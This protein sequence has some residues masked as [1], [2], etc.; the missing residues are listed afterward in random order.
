M[1]KKNSRFVTMAVV[2]C[3]LFTMGLMSPAMAKVHKVNIN[4]ADKAQLMTL[5]YIGQKLAERIIEYRKKTPFKSANEIMMVKG[6]GPK[7]F[8]VNKDKIIVKKGDK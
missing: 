3:L 8:E 7:V 1:I 5:K 2:I 4:T 6:I